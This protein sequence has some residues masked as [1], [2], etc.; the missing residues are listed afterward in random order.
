MVGRQR[1]QRRQVDV[2]Q[3]LGQPPLAGAAALLARQQAGRV[4][5]IEQDHAALRQVGFDALDARPA[6]GPGGSGGTGQ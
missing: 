6:P 4:A 2:V 3:Q 5:G 1:D